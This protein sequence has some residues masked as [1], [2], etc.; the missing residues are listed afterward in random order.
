[1]LG[2]QKRRLFLL[3]GGAEYVCAWYGAGVKSAEASRES[4]VRRQKCHWM[5]TDARGSSGKD[6]AV[7]WGSREHCANEVQPREQV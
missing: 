4:K 5:D 7:G 2:N 6:R 3:M 1:M